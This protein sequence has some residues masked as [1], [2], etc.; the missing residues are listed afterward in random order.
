MTTAEMIRLAQER[1][2]PLEDGT[3]PRPYKDLKE[4]KEGRLDRSTIS[5]AIKKAFVQRLVKIVPTNIGPEP[6]RVRDLELELVSELGLN[7]VLVIRPVMEGV[8]V[9][10]PDE[11]NDAVHR[12]IG[13]ATGAMIAQGGIF[14]NGDRIACA[15]GRSC[16][17]TVHYLTE[18][19]TSS[20][21]N[22]ELIS[23]AGNL[24]PRHHRILPNLRLDADLNTQEL[25][26]SFANEAI[27]KYVGRH[28]VPR[29][30]VETL[31]KQNDALSDATWK[32]PV[33]VA[34]FGVGLFR[35]GH[36]LF[37]IA[38]MPHPD[39]AP[40][41]AS[42]R[43]LAEI[44]KRYTTEDYCPVA[45]VANHL[46]FVRPLDQAIPS[47]VKQRIRKLITSVNSHTLTVSDEQLHSIQNGIL[48]AGTVYKTAAVLQLLRDLNV[49]YLC[50]D[51]D[52]ATHLL[53]LLRNE[54][55]GAHTA[56]QPAQKNTR[57]HTKKAL[58]RTRP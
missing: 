39:F 37:T 57:T 38:N 27:A 50:T 48:I 30:H 55:T 17:H 6:E 12:Q 43:E 58:N 2:L 31:R 49:R 8:D 32:R 13:I 28:A 21:R 47:S 23:M 25:A 16:Y 15:S 52:L 42:L 54:R 51:V 10:S 41:Q 46:L 45:D 29:S 22:V 1:H 44:A 26:R 5:R 34:I 53:Q 14:R 20:L 18:G 35:T 19:M 40:I 36:R 3:W 24:Q 33:D 56:A 9:S 7:T 4:L 11:V